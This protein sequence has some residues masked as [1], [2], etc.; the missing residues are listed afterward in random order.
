MTL[1]DPAIGPPGR[2]IFLL[3]KTAHPGEALHAKALALPMVLRTEPWSS[4]GQAYVH[5]I[6]YDAAE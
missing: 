3:M 4:P 2:K 5:Q 6:V 1:A